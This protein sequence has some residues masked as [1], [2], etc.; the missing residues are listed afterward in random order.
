MKVDNYSDSDNALFYKQFN[1]LLDVLLGISNPLTAYNTILKILMHRFNAERCLIIKKGNS[2]NEVIA[3]SNEIL[4]KDL[5]SKSILKAAFAANSEFLLENKK[6]LKFKGASLSNRDITAMVIPLKTVYEDYGWL[7]LDRHHVSYNHIEM[8]LLKSFAEKLIQ[9]LRWQDLY[10]EEND[11]AALKWG[12]FAGHSELMKNI[13]HQLQSAARTR[14]RCIIIEGESGTG[15]ELAARAIHLLSNRCNKA[16]IVLNCA[17]IKPDLMESELFGYYHDNSKILH[18]DWKGLIE[19]ADGGI[20]FLDEISNLNYQVQARLMR[21]IEEQTFRKIGSY[22]ELKVD[23]RFIVST[24]Q[25]LTQMVKRGEFRN[26]LYQRLNILKI[27][28][29]PLRKHKDDIIAIARHLLKEINHEYGFL[30]SGL[31]DEV[32]EYLNKHNWKDGNVRE[33]KNF[34][35]RQAVSQQG[36]GS[37]IINENYDLK[38]DIPEAIAGQPLTD[39]LNEIKWERIRQTWLECDKNKTK[40]AELLGT[41]RR[42]LYRFL[43]EFE[44]KYGRVL[45]KD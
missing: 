28:M 4:E 24:N 43:S 18:Q 45:L 40:T 17:Q 27:T 44:K 20:L 12:L 3:S 21:I 9:L 32:H 2:G 34:L 13:Y 29:P 6:D 37:L 5:Y 14:A 26:D 11:A 8:N 22:Q 38:A 30:I 33:L 7:Y 16:F 41:P 42:Q 23:I 1:L 39:Y 35:Q 25:D 31:S 10:Q 15:K 36:K 19:E